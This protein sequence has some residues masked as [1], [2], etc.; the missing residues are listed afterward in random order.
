MLYSSKTHGKESRP[1]EVKISAIANYRIQEYGKKLHFCPFQLARNYMR[2]R[3]SYK[4]DDDPFFI[5]R[6]GTP[7]TPANVRNLLRLMLEKLGL[8]PVLYDTHSWRV[9]RATQLFKNN[10]DIARIRFLGRWKSNAVYKY[11]RDL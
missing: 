2:L 9:G 8:N 11:L 3:G 6:D 4:N 10:F 1:Q 7:V 5:F